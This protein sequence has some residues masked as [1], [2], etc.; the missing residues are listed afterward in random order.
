MR[1]GGNSSQE[2]GKKLLKEYQAIYNIIYLSCEREGVNIEISRPRLADVTIHSQKDILKLEDHQGEKIS[3]TKRIAG[4]AFWIRR[5]KPITRA[6]RKGS[7]KEIH[8]INE[9]CA[10]WIA[11]RVLVDY[12]KPKNNNYI[13]K[14]IDN[15]NVHCMFREYLR[16]FWGIDDFYNYHMMVYSLHYRNFSPHHLSL[17]FDSIITGFR[18][19]MIG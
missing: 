18:L 14:D 17:L 3:P 7:S 13:F 5:I 6:Y 15:P 1:D 4:L 8:D 16:K 9:Q 19:K 2:F 12:A 10:I 11:S